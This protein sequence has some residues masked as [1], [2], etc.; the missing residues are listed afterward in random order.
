MPPKSNVTVNEI[1]SPLTLPFLI[2]TE[3]PSIPSVV[4]VSMAPSAL[5]SYERENRPSAC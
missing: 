2:G 1:L 3:P 5:N 4:P